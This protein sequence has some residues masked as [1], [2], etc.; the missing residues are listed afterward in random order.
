MERDLWDRFLVQKFRELKV[1]EP[2]CALGGA[3]EAGRPYLSRY[4]AITWIVHN[5]PSD[6]NR[7]V[8]F[9]FV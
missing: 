6:R 4:R 3:R 5:R 2:A 8:R 7:T 1:S 9:T